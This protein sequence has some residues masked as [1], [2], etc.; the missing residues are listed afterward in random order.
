MTVLKR[1]LLRIVAG[2]VFVVVVVAASDN[3]DSVTLRFL[4]FE[5]GAMPVSWWVLAAFLAGWL[6]SSMFGLF[7]TIGLRQQVRQ[8]NKTTVRQDAKAEQASPQNS[9]QK[10]QRNSQ[11]PVSEVDQSAST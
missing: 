4:D 10:S 2:I 11:S 5:S 1:W 6:L 8:A 9:P 3:S 7:V